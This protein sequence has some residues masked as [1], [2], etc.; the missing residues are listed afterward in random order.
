MKKHNMPK[1]SIIINCY[2]GEQYL[3]QTLNSIK[4][5]SYD[6]YEIIFWDN[7]STDRSAEIA[8]RHGDRLKYYCSKHTVPLGEARNYAINS[9]SGEYIAFLDADDLWSKNKLRVQVN[10]LDEHKEVGLVH[11]NF[12]SYN[13][14]DDTKVIVHKDTQDRLVGFREFVC[15]YSYCMST[16]MVRKEALDELDFMFDTRLEYAEEFDL[17]SRIVYKCDV[18]YIGK[19]LVVRRM[20][21]SMNSR[22]LTGRISEE[23][24]ICLEN[25]CNYVPDIKTKYLAVYKHISYLVDFTN[26]KYLLSEGK[27]KNVAKIMKP[28][29]FYN[30][31]ALLF[32][33]ISFLPSRFSLVVYRYFYDK[34]F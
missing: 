9:A 18:Y 26:A 28:H 19:P 33:L 14:F 4:S 31:R 34:R 16:F 32:I 11:S 15:H 17:F 30:V 13:M 24:K 25:L 2:N 21:E 7:S 22:K 12:Y 3:Q 6:D 5:Q 10:I 1:V 8:K 23:H 20:H 27:N 29:I